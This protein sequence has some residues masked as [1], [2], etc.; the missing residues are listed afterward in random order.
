MMFGGDK[1]RIDL[2]TAMPDGEVV[3]PALEIDAAHLHDP[4]P[5]PLRAVVDRQLLQ[6]H[7]AMGNR[8][9]LQIVLL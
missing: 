3:K 8:V 7:H 1:P 2:E 6:Q 4:K 5:P 9:K